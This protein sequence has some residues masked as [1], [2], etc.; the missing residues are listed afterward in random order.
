[1]HG[2]R[3]GLSRGLRDCS[4]MLQRCTQLQR[5]TLQRCGPISKGML[6]TLVAQLGMRQVVLRGEHGLAAGTIS[7]LQ[8]LGAAEGCELLC[9]AEVQ[10][11]PLCAQYFVI[12]V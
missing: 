6:L 5:V 10:P 1:M 4:G 3:Q 12:T 7:E 8:A 11:G 2:G 9:K